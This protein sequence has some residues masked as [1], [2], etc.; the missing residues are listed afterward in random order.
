MTRPLLSNNWYR[1]RSL[2]P[3]L[4][5]HVQVH[6]HVYRGE[7]WYVIEDRVGGKHQR[8]NFASY[9]VLNLLDGQRTMAEVW[10]LLSDELT[11]DTPTQDDVIRL[12]GQ[13]HAADLVLMDVT[14]DVA[15][16]FERRGKQQRR[17][18]ISR[19][20]NPVALRFPLFDPDPTLRWLLRALRPLFGW[21]GVLLWLLL[22]LPALLL[23]PT[24]WRE[25]GGNLNERLLA[26]NNLLML[27]LLFPLVK[28]V[29]EF[30]HGLACRMRGGE[31][32][33][34]GVML[35]AMYPIPYVDVS[36]ASAFVG[37]WQRALV[38]AAGMLAELALA[39]IAFYF[40]LLLEPGVARAVAYNV[41]VLASVTTLFFNANPLLR[42]DGYYILADLIEVPNLG[43]RANRHWQYLAE[44][45]VF[46]VRNAQPPAATP[47]E[48][49]WFIGYAP[50]AYVYRLLVSIGIALFV[51]QQFFFI[52]VLM[53]IWTVASGV[54]WPIF[55]GLRALATAPQF[56]DRGARVRGV[57]AG[58]AA[59]L[60]VGLFVVPLPYHTH[61]DGVLWLPEQAILR[62]QSNGFARTLHAEPGTILAVGQPVLESVEPGLA[63]RVAAQQAR[64]QETQVQHTAAWATAPARARQLEQ[65]LAREQAAL[66]R[67]QSE[68]D[69]LVLRS[70]VAGTLLM[71]KAAD[72]PGRWLKK[73]EVVGYV[74]SSDAPLVRLVVSQAEADTVRLDTRSVQVRLAQG[75]D[76]PWPAKLV[77]AVPAAS[78]E[79]PSAALGEQGGGAAIV[80]PR[81]KRGLAT[82]QSVFEFELALP[83]EV[84]HDFLGSHV[85]VRFEH[86]AEPLGWRL[87]RGVRRAF[88][89]H[90]QL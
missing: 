15:E 87:W 7:A 6:R 12:L 27:A 29:H 20:A 22:V 66:G 38:G 61:A 67:L 48:R 1:L 65:D 71:A 89:S 32:H 79:L 17:K 3:R 47:G 33:E 35:L 2:K 55:K 18:W 28:V 5:G 58:G 46:G 53:G 4:R 45:W 19:L 40:W 43:T 41:A 13:L 74:R 37:K 50:L 34:M 75:L 56:A 57:L 82:L 49:R 86:G 78:R 85:H 70:G 60:G 69:G 62:A 44:R 59:L 16:L 36:N 72:L 14:P 24:H 42:Y 63:A 84:P 80:D 52:G 90:F 68:A 73:G 31:V 8:F 10:A 25:L 9:R 23:V 26:G 51:A 39:A 54:L 77:R 81:D 83:K 21:P 76:G 11:D 88:L 30:A 64:V